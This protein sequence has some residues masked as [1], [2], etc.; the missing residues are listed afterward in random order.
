MHAVDEVA[1]FELRDRAVAARCCNGCV[2]RSADTLRAARW[3]RSFVGC[4]EAGRANGPQAHRATELPLIAAFGFA[5]S[6]GSRAGHPLARWLVTG[7]GAAER[8]RVG[9]NVPA[10]VAVLDVVARV[11]AFGPAASEATIRA[12][13]P[14]A[15][16]RGRASCARVRTA[17]ARS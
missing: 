16:P 12:A 5:T 1:N 6:R 2:G 17:C 11:D 9:T 14:A 3:A 10:R 8:S 7:S 4:C 15:G 13:C